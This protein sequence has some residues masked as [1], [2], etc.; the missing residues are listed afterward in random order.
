MGN[1]DW[2]QLE[3]EIKEVFRGDASGHD[4]A[5]TLRVANL[6][7]VI[8]REEGADEELCRLA[9]LL[10]DVDDW[11]LVGGAMGQSTRARA[12]MARHHVGKDTQE[13]VVGI[14]ASVSFKGTD[15][16]VPP[17]LE[18]KVVQ[19]ADRLDAIGAIGV[20]RAFAYGGAHGRVMYDPEIP[21]RPDMD[22]KAYMANRGTT[23][24]HFYEKLLLLGD[25]MQTVAGKTIAA[26]RHAYL[27]AFLEEFLA[28]W[29]GNR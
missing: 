8:A 23:I 9:A 11:K 18:G 17:T 5:H 29:Q 10:H 28:E 26:S 15:S 13:Q 21:P 25:M 19:D 20:A 6:A 3:S 27:K 14:I 16:V 2:N 22:E 24:N 4:A 7:R 1:P 12:L